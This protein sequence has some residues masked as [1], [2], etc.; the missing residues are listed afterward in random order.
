MAKKRTKDKSKAAKTPKSDASVKLPKNFKLSGETLASLITSP[1]VR[2]MAADVLIAVAGALAANRR[3]Q[4]AAA[5]LAG[6]AS[7]AAAAVSAGAQTATGAVAGVVAEAA[8]RILPSST[9]AEGGS[10]GASARARG[11]PRPANDGPS[12]KRKPRADAPEH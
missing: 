8:R 2:E 10:E 5:N 7:D 1:V 3:P 4:K 6:N 11:Y 9:T 12:R